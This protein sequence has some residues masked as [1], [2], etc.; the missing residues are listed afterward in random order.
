M[1]RFLK[2]GAD[3]VAKPVSALCNLSATR[4]IFPSAC[5]VAKLKPIFQ[6]GK[7]TDPW[8]Y[9]PIFLLPVTSIVTERVVHVQTTTFLSDENKLLN[10]KSGFR[11]K[12]LCLFFLTDN[13]L[14][15]F[16]ERLLT[17][18]ILIDLQ[19]AFDT[20]DHEILLQKPK[21]IRFSK[22]TLQWFRFNLSEPIFVVDIESEL[23]DFGQISCGL[24]QCSIFGSLLFSIYVN[25]KP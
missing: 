24:P 13:I 17:G 18:T 10:Y 25:D 15:E 5:K 6:K 21:G 23:S 14:K 2:D 7:K 3:I 22:E 16:H 4:R 12:N 9:R 20:I 11:A 8:N 19:K 1:G